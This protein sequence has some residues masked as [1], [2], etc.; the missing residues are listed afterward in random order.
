MALKRFPAFQSLKD[1]LISKTYRKRYDKK[2]FCQM[3]MLFYQE[4]AWK[5]EQ[6][7][8]KPAVFSVDLKRYLKEKDQQ[9]LKAQIPP[10]T[11]QHS[12]PKHMTHTKEIHN[13]TDNIT[14]IPAG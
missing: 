8:N 10:G 13:D 12:A 2:I 4:T 9:H 11:N 14:N 5:K 3:Y 1:L 7:H 6:H